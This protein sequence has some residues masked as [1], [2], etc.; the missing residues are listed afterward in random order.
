[1]SETI[2]RERAE[3]PAHIPSNLA[4]FTHHGVLMVRTTENHEAGVYVATDRHGRQY[5]VRTASGTKR[6][7]VTVTDQF[8]NCDRAKTLLLAAEW[9]SRLAERRSR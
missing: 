8:G 3:R 1:M 6:Y 2:A 7:P 9:I 4:E 5:D